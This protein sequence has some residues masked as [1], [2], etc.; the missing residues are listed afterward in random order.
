M[1]HM[2]KGHWGLSLKKRERIGLWVTSL[3]AGGSYLKAVLSWSI[4]V[5]LD[6]VASL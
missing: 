2:L 4:S 1:P 6:P 5:G 3:T